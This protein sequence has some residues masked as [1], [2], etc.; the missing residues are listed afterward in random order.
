M[1]RSIGTGRHSTH[2]FLTA[3]IGA[4]PRDE[5]GASHLAR[6]S[7]NAKAFLNVKKAERTEKKRQEEREKRT[8]RCQ[9]GTGGRRIF[10]KKDCF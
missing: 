3:A 4:K 1:C 8:G 5:K 2:I 6:R 7:E 10:E 9:K